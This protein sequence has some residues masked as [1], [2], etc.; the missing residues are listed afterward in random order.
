MFGKYHDVNGLTFNVSLISKMER[1]VLFQYMTGVSV[2]TGCWFLFFN[3]FSGSFNL[4]E[5]MKT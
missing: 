5:N 1:D 2:N 3:E 4:N